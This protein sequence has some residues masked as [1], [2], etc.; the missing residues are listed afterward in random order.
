M[1]SGGLEGVNAELLTDC[2][3]SV[4]HQKGGVLSRH[5]LRI[6]ASNKS[7]SL[8]GQ[9]THYFFWRKFSLLCLFCL[10]PLFSSS[11]TFDSNQ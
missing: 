6:L 8:E 11:D 5:S 3:F 2:M 7:V 10:E 1:L 9:F 4:S